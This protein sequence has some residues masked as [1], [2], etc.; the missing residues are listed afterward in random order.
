MV[1]NV[2]KAEL[3]F[4]TD[5]EVSQA[6]GSLFWRY[7]SY[8][9]SFGSKVLGTI[10]MFRET[11]IL[12]TS[13]PLPLQIAHNIKWLLG[14]AP[15]QEFM[16]EFPSF[17]GDRHIFEANETE[18]LKVFFKEHRNDKMFQPP[19]SIMMFQQLVSDSFPDSKFTS[20]DVMFTCGKKMTETYRHL[21]LQKM[22]G[23]QKIDSLPIIKEERQKLLNQ[24]ETKCSLGQTVN[25]TTDLRVFSS[26]IITRML[27]GNTNQTSELAEA[28][29]F[30]N[31]Y[32]AETIFK[33]GI[34]RIIDSVTYLLGYK[35][36]TD[37]LKDRYDDA[38]K[39]FNKAVNEI[40]QNKS[41]PL[42]ENDQLLTLAQKQAL[43][44]IIFFAGQETTASL[45]TYAISVLAKDPEL[46]SQLRRDIENNSQTVLHNFF[47]RCLRE[48]PPAYGISRKLK[49]D[50]CMEYTMRNGVSLKKI[51]F[52]DEV[53]TVFLF[54]RQGKLNVSEKKE[55]AENKHTYYFGGGPHRCPGEALARTE[56]REMISGL[57]L[58]YHL[59]TPQTEENKL[60]GK[61]TLQLEKD[62]LITVQPLEEISV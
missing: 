54:D 13:T 20:D 53:L 43:I 16:T 47:E 35:T 52:K 61:I 34:S 55:S 4:A 46:Q 24:W 28:V 59:S 12:K 39:V 9:C 37:Q 36:E 8:P 58:N 56:F 30:I 50:V 26:S 31:F 48:F 19:R 22:S 51:F 18:I 27:L 3:R 2:V 57:L 17:L 44:F 11:N 38:L 49:T 15:E 62:V 5:E 23:N 42:F 29:N 40:L 14:Y 33:S 41:I 32:I 60:L 7:A 45:I 6:K 10:K 1:N 25:A 21:I